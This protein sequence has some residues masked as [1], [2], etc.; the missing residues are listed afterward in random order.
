MFTD[1]GAV[2]AGFTKDAPRLG[3]GIYLLTD[4][5]GSSFEAVE[6]TGGKNG[7]GADASGE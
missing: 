3:G 7:A 6:A 1:A 5:I 4:S 2:G